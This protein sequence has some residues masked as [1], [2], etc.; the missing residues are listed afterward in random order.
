MW[1]IMPCLRQKANII[2]LVHPSVRQSRSKGYT[3]L[4]STYPNSLKNI[5]QVSLDFS[6]GHGVRIHALE[7]HPPIFL[8]SFATTLQKA[9]MEHRD[10]ASAILHQ[11]LRMEIP[12]SIATV[13]YY[14]EVAQ[15]ALKNVVCRRI[16]AIIGVFVLATDANWPCLIVDV[17][18]WRVV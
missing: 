6:L 10:C 17:V 11:G 14:E 13:R 18:A 12:G 15:R 1:Q 8:H 4:S 9:C 5:V 3:C 7:L 2:L 16:A